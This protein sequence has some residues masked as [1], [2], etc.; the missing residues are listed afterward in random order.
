MLQVMVTGANKLFRMWI[1]GAQ[2]SG[3]VY[4]K[5]DGDQNIDISD[6]KLVAL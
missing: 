5:C 6:E 2:F 3:T 4:P 1:E